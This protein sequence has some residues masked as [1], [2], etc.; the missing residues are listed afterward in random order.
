M[1][2]CFII[3]DGKRVCNKQDVVENCDDRGPN[4]ECQCLLP[5]AK[6]YESESRNKE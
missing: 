4:D 6:K 3:Q 1:D 2:C 5:K